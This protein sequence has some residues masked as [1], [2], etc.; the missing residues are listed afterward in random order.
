[1]KK[2]N[3][4]MQGLLVLVLSIG[5]S[6]V[7]ITVSKENIEKVATTITKIIT[8]D[9]TEDTASADAQ[10]SIQQLPYRVISVT[11]GDTLHVE[12]D[13]VN[14]TIRVLGIDTP[15]TKY[16]SRGEECFGAEASVYAK[17]LLE[18]S[19]VTLKQDSSQDSRDKYNRFLAYVGLADGRDFGQ[20]MI[21]DGYA[22]E[23]TFKRKVY[24]KQAVYREAQLRA[25]EE[26]LGLWEE[27][28]CG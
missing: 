17:T 7:G 5:V 1:M 28:V 12:I 18:G 27:G 26:G 6:Y 22:Y 2:Q 20:V 25:Q 13:G 8:K 4:L 10:E 15:E 11:D 21:A 3:M 16:S 24:E 14:E 9:T 23:Y 19:E